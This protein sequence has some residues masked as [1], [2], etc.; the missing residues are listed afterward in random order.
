MT[1]A[2]NTKFTVSLAL[3]LAMALFVWHAAT[4]IAVIESDIA[5]VKYQVKPIPQMQQD[6]AVIKA[7]LTDNPLS[8]K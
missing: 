2:K 7:V 3:L 4:K 5:A 6:I 8:K 1:L